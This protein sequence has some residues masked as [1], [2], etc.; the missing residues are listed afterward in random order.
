MY[1]NYNQK[2]LNLKNRSAF[3]KNALAV[4]Q[5]L[6]SKDPLNEMNK[7]EI[8]RSNRFIR[9]DGKTIYYKTWV[10]VIPFNCI[11][12]PFCASFLA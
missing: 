2:F 7:Q 1:R 11:A 5:E 4:W 12:H 10:K 8:I 9:I 3:Y 6:Y